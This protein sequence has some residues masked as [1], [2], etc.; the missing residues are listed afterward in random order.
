MLLDRLGK[1]VLLFDGAMGSQLQ[2]RGLKP[3]MIPE[4]LNISD[5]EMIIDIHSAY[6]Q[7][8]ADFVTTNT[9]GCNPIKM[10]ASRYDYREMIKAAVACA[11]SAIEK[12]GKKAYTVLDIGPIGQ[13]MEPMGTLKFS[14]AYDVFRQMILC[15]KDEVDLILFETMSDLY[16][17]RGACGEGKQ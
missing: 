1:E 9:F 14:E 3:G 12:T 5:P 10:A 7:A 8:G 2:Q 15:A 6:L 13:L 11:R 16:E 4:E 17:S